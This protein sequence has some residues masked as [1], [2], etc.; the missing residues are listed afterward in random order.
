MRIRCI[1]SQSNAITERLGYSWTKNNALFHSD[2]QFEMWEELYPEGSILTIQNIH[3]S[4]TYSCSISNSLASV[5]S[6]IHVNIVDLELMSICRENISYG[7][8]WPA[9]SS[10]PPVL[11]DCPFGYNG[12]ASRFCEQRDYNKSEW[13]QPDFSDCI[14]QKLLRIS[15]EVSNPLRSMKWPLQCHILPFFLET[16]SLSVVPS[17][18][19]NTIMC[20]LPYGCVRKSSLLTY[21]SQMAAEKQCLYVCHPQCKYFS[22]RSLS[23]FKFKDMFVLLQSWRNVQSINKW[24]ND[25]LAINLSCWFCYSVY[26]AERYHE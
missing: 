8:K 23:R 18:F 4:A 22:I 13:L 25:K 19:P 3:K 10:G 7:I 17:H 26:I 6:S 24:T 1:A 20:H 14:N 11:S 12:L 21:P 15:T 9:S 2:P 16:R 5:F